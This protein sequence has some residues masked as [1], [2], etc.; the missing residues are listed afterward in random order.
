MALRAGIEISVTEGGR[1]APTYDLA[2]DI[3]GDLTFADLLRFTKNAL[4]TISTDTLREEQGRGFD[5]KPIRLV[6]GK[7]G[8]SEL[9][10]NPLGSIEYR[11][12]QDPRKIITTIYQ[13]ILARSPVRTGEYAKAN[14]VAFNGVQ[15]ANSAES[16]QAWLDTAPAFTDRDRIRFINTSPYAR[17]LERY[18]VSKGRQRSVSRPLGKNERDRVGRQRLLVPNGTYALAYRSIRSKFKA[19]SFIAFDLIPGDKLGISQGFGSPAHSKLRRTFA[20]NRVNG[21]SAG[22]PYLYPTIL[23][24]VVQAGLNQ[25][26]TLQ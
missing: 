25:E 9:D 24:Y 17:K 20:K 3:K 5:K 6:D 2:S 16:L 7:V 21:S 15:V 18:G 1:K 19:N 10:V 8:R 4:I 13:A 23:L 26:N 12:R 11:S 22:R 14:V